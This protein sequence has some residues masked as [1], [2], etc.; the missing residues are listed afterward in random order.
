MTKCSGC[1]IILQNENKLDL[2]YTPKLD[3]EYCERC[4][5]TIHYGKSSEVNNLNNDNIITK[6]NKLNYFTFFI[7]DFLN[8]NKSVID[9]YNQI[10]TKKILLV[11]KIDLLP[12]NL[13]LTHIIENIQNTYNI[14]DMIVLSGESEYGVNK[15]IDL[16]E[17]NENVV[18]CGETSSGKSTL[19]N[20]ILD[21]KLTTS[22]FDNTTLDFIKLDYLKYTIYDTP[23]FILD[24]KTYYNKIKV[25]PK[26]LKKDFELWIGNYVIKA[27]EDIPVTLFVKD[28][29]MI[30]SKKNKLVPKEKIN[31]NMRS[32]L[33]LDDIGF[34]YIKNNCDIYINKIVEVRKS[35]IGG[36]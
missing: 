34:I 5:K 20:K 10:T 22:K 7:T 16:I 2:G 28:N 4:F 18:F 25:L 14:K 29:V 21:T 17:E 8:I 23:G 11:N 33:Y 13:K 1:G 24:K 31:I 32:D 6:I 36:K 30:K 19:I 26:I 35:I 27:N 15:V 12:D 3:N 9:M